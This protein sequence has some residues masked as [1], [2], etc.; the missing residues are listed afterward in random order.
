[1]EQLKGL[2][3]KVGKRRLRDDRNGWK[4]PSFVDVAY[5][6]GAT[7]ACSRGLRRSRWIQHI[8]R[9]III[10]SPL[11]LDPPPPAPSC[12]LACG[13]RRDLRYTNES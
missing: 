6:T 8:A 9:S 5:K 10:I 3:G 7:N 4:A 13:I 1:M 11:S 2:V 12:W